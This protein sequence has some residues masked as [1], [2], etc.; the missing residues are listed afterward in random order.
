MASLPSSSGKAKKDAKNQR[1]WSQNSWMAPAPAPVPAPAPSVAPAPELE[2][3][4]EDAVWAPL[5]PS[6]VT[7]CDC[8]REVDLEDA[9]ETRNGH[10]TH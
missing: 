7:C 4:F 5:E 10:S 2:D 9:V 6:L 8:A 3:G 1:K